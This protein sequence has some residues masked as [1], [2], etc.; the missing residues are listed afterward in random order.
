MPSPPSSFGWQQVSQA[1]LQHPP[2]TESVPAQMKERRSLS[3]APIAQGDRQRT[4]EV[5]IWMA[6]IVALIKAVRPAGLSS[7]PF[8]PGILAATLSMS[9]CSFERFS[10][11]T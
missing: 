1:T 11:Y 3:M 6:D 10:L 2:A 5:W 8:H 4:M 7:C 9:S